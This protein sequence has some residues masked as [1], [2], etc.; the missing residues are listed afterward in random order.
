MA[1]SLPEWSEECGAVHG[2]PQ[3]LPQLSVC[4]SLGSHKIS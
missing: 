4:L 1:S 3:T 2:F